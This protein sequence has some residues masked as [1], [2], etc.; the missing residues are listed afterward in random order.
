MTGHY[1]IMWKTVSEDCNLACDYCYYSR[2]LGKPEQVRTPPPNVLEKVCTIILTLV[3][4]RLPLPGR[5]VNR[6]SPDYSFSARS[7]R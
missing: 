4:R 5:A 3:G 2:V 7:S 1:G 6:C